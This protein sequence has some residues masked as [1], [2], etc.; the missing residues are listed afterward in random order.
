[1][2]LVLFV[3]VTYANRAYAGPAE[4][5]EGT[6]ALDAP[7]QFFGRF[8]FWIATALTKGVVLFIDQ[9]VP[10][11]TYNNF[12]TNPVVSAGWAIVRDTVNMFFVVVLIVIA[13][14]TIF[15]ASRFQWQ[16]Q[17]PR[18][19]IF[20]LVINFS[21]TLTGL[22]IDFGQVVML[23]FANAI[24]EIAA[25]NF[26]QLLGLGEIYQISESSS[27]IQDLGKQGSKGLGDSFEYL[28]GG[29]MAVG[30]VV[31]VLATMI[32]LTVILLYRIVMLWVM[33][34]IAP[35]AWFMGGAEGVVKS[36]AYQQWWDRFKCLVVIGPVL[37]FFLW[38]TLAVAGAGN[39]AQSSGFNV[40]NNQNTADFIL[41]FFE[42]QHF[43]SF[44]IG[45]AMLYAGFEAAQTACSSMSGSFIGRSLKK[46]QGAPAV[47]AGAAAGIGLKVGAG[48]GRKAGAAARGAVKG[49][50]SFLGVNDLVSKAKQAGYSRIADATSGNRLLRP[51]T[52]KARAEAAGQKSQR[53][54][55]VTKRA[56]KFK[57]YEQKD[58]VADLTSRIKDPSIGAGGKKDTLALM[59]KLIK[60]P[61]AM[62]AFR[63]Q[64]DRGGNNIG[65]DLMQKMFRDQGANFGETFKGDKKMQKSFLDAKK[66]NVDLLDRTDKADTLKKMDWKDLQNM[67]T[68]AVGDSSVRDRLGSMKSGIKRRGKDKDGN[69]LTGVMTAAEALQQGHGG[70]RLTDAWKAQES[71]GEVKRDTNAKIVREK[72]GDEMK[73]RMDDALTDRAESNELVNTLSSEYQNP[74]TSPEQ[75]FNIAS[76]MEKIE[77]DI[78]AKL[79]T[80]RWASDGQPDARVG[81]Y[82]GLLAALKDGRKAGQDDVVRGGGSPHGQVP[83]LAVLAG[84]TAGFSGE[85]FANDNFSAATPDERL[86]QAS[87]QIAEQ[88]QNL[89]KR[90]GDM[91]AGT[92]SGDTSAL[93]AQYDGLRQSIEDNTRAQLSDK[94]DQLAEIEVKLNADDV[95]DSDATALNQQKT[96]INVEINQQIQ[97]DVSAS[98]QLD[99]I[100]SQLA[101]A[102]SGDEKIAEEIGKLNKALKET[103]L[104]HAAVGKFQAGK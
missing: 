64:K 10:I 16:Q 14:G 102:G 11:L 44:L 21:K 85:Q 27:A 57:D 1:M 4:D 90:I 93:Q 30:M 19:M 74:N 26:I 63:D 25:G 97:N 70:E 86:T 51:L 37:T 92:A 94:T 58:V 46:G 99:D 32:I 33:I 104:A 9:L 50:G 39:I 55:D 81:Q 22:M 28:A 7:L 62:R 15:G 66:Q 73:A 59:S 53:A 87:A 101:S 52:S 96:E 98:S 54:A 49:A 47:I 103:Q 6:A 45:M 84:A 80:A 38:L 40:A 79:K 69:K 71:A 61:K 35:L 77:V 12:S 29:I 75:R 100:Q 13:F 78:E 88:V 20:A 2:F 56:D 3:G 23:T 83:D 41:K 36:G 72:T 95:S 31:W 89:E 60:D 48:A 8:A 18:L 76:G 5:E 17:V 43:M 42:S 65:N 91:S 24:R 82:E 68:R 67:D 34:V